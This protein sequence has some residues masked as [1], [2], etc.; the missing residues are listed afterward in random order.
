MPVVKLTQS[1]TTKKKKNNQP[2][3]LSLRRVFR[4][5]RTPRNEIT[6]RRKSRPWV[7]APPPTAHAPGFE[8]Y[9]VPGAIIYTTVSH[10]C[11][12][13]RVQTNSSRRNLLSAI[14]RWLALFSFYVKD[15]KG[16]LTVSCDLI[17]FFLKECDVCARVNP[18]GACSEPFSPGTFGPENHNH[19]HD[20]KW[21]RVMVVNSVTDRSWA[22]EKQSWLEQ[23]SQDS[24]NMSTIS[25]SLD[26]TP[27]SILRVSC[28]PGNQRRRATQK[29]TTTA[30][31][32]SD[33][34]IVRWVS[35]GFG[36]FLPQFRDKR[37][38]NISDKKPDFS[39]LKK[40]VPFFKS[41]VLKY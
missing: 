19:K 28:S 30:T 35:F 4:V 21:T 29:R 8:L 20:R 32:H 33:N 1:K 31:I 9:I 41:F 24:R 14:S 39:A 40:H 11:W 26:P 22:G 16:H 2:Q 10:V 6:N 7:R 36:S 18:K 12:P 5:P 13:V 15:G 27:K 37:K 38:K 17:Y 3:T 23:G 34:F 25:G